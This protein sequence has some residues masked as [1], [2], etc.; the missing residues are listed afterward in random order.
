MNREQRALIF[1]NDTVGGDLL[2]VLGEVGLSPLQPHD[3][4]SNSGEVAVIILDRAAQNA[5]AICTNLRKQ[6]NFAK[7]PIL[8]LLDGAAQEEVKLLT[9]LNADLFFKPVGAMALRRYFRAKVTGSESSPPSSDGYGTQA[10]VDAQAEAGDRANA[11]TVVDVDDSI[12]TSNRLLPNVLVPVQIAKGGVPCMRCGRWKARR[13]DAFCSRCGE[14]LAR[15][16][17]PT[18]AIFEPYGE[19]RVGHLIELKNVGQNPLH[20]NFSILAS[21]QLTQRFDLHT[22]HG[23]LDGGQAE[24]LLVTFDA[25]GLD[26]TTRYQTVLEISSNEGGLSKR[27]VQLI[28]ERLP[29]PRVVAD[30]VYVFVLGA[31]NQWDFRLSNDGG[32]TLTFTK[33]YLDE[34]DG[35]TTS[36]RV[37]LELIEPVIIKGAS[38]ATVRFRLP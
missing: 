32:G 12:P 9:G 5:V 16:D 37:E 7:T 10:G 35:D 17:A 4:A 23:V 2:N 19:H 29:I 22:I 13:E 24:H 14:P 26:L 34:P 33:L 1:A 28:V 25:R 21:S 11:R 31:E 18:T 3:L 8:V 6:E 15:L 30:E 36:S 27:Q 20:M 38:S